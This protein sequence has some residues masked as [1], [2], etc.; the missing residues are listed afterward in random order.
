MTKFI[1]IP[2][3]SARR[4]FERGPFRYGTSAKR[5]AFHDASFYEGFKNAIFQD[6]FYSRSKMLN[7]L[8]P[9]INEA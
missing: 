6:N 3:E 5:A 9:W 2:I 4:M 1:T 7:A 8:P